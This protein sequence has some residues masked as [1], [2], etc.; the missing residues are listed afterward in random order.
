[1]V[2]NNTTAKS[3]VD[4]ACEPM[5]YEAALT[6]WVKDRI[7]N[8]QY[9][10]TELHVLSFKMIAVAKEAARVF[11]IGGRAK[12]EEIVE[13]G[14]H[15][16]AESLLRSG[17]DPLQRLKRL[18]AFL[19]MQDVPFYDDLIDETSEEVQ[20]VQY[21][22][23]RIQPQYKASQELAPNPAL[24]LFPPQVLHLLT[25]S[26]HHALVCLSLNHFI[27]SLPLGAG[28]T[29]VM[30]RTKV[31]QHRGAA[32]RALSRHIAQDKT[33]C[34]DM[35]ITTI[36]MFMC[37]E[38]QNPTFADGRSHVNA[39]KRIVDLRGGPKQVMKE[40]PY[41]IQPMVLYLLPSWD[42]VD[43]S[44]TAE[45]MREDI[46]DMYSL[47]FPYTLCPRELFT[48]ILRTN[49]LRAKASAAIQLCDFNPDHALEAYDVLGRI[50]AFPVEDWARA[51]TFCTE[52]LTVGLVYKSAVALYATLSLCPLMVLPTIP[53][54]LESQTAYGDVLLSNLGTALKAP[55]MAKFMVWPLIV[56]GVEAM[57]RGE[58]TRNWIEAGLEDLSRTLG[59]SCPLKVCSVLKRYWKGGVAGWDECFDQSYVFAI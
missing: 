10:V 35:T 13:K 54:L 43:I 19:S 2:T 42:Q 9:R 14:L 16:E 7:V 23:V 21:Y 50:E 57:H 6:E 4:Y 3:E 27:Y 12:I 59:T 38:L 30:A 26:I 32:L 53:S 24:V 34:S 37:L 15:E 28:H 41:L 45:E 17:R 48:E 56:A 11:E 47:I 18:L 44:N 29:A 20:A 49:Q 31:Y 5:D 25:P 39:M 40:A 58:G 46:T 52:W 36:L 22:N 51:G 55:R 8:P 33:R 1:M